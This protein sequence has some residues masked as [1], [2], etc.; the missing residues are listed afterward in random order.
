MAF[1]GGG[2]LAG[3]GL[4]AIISVGL[5]ETTFGT[6]AAAQIWAGILK[7]CQFTKED[8]IHP[9]RGIGNVRT[10]NSLSLMYT[11]YGFRLS[12][13]V[14]S[15][16]S[17]AMALGAISGTA[18]PTLTIFKGSEHTTPTK[19][20]LPSWTIR[21][22]YD[23]ATD[24]S[25][26][27]KGCTVNSG[28]FNI[29]LD[30]PFTFALEGPAKSQGTDAATAQTSPATAL[31]SWNTTV[32]VKEGG[33]AYSAGGAVTIDGL[34]SIGFSIN[35]N[36]AVRNEFGPTAPVAIRQPIPGVADLELKLTRGFIDDDL[37]DDLCD[38]TVQSFQIV[39]TDGTN[40]LTLEFDNCLSKSTG[41]TTNMDGQSE[42]T[43]TYVVKTM[44]CVVADSLTYTTWD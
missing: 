41:H 36:L 18:D 15:G 25:I 4:N 30:G 40:T 26:S 32:K 7:E 6:A 5:E 23:E 20:F 21:R 33:T 17:L 1:A 22:T 28:D 34:K 12:G 13:E 43:V 9:G 8:G 10:L 19:T 27:L 44:D 2:N 39:A 3:S 11:K 37:W 29:D 16:I 14:D 42:E 38:G 35:H 31:G 24:D